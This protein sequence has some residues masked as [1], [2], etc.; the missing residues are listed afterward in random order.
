MKLET[1]QKYIDIMDSMIDS[2]YTSVRDYCEHVGINY[3]TF[4]VQMYNMRKLAGQ[5]SE[6]CQRAIDKYE[7]VKE[8]FLQGKRSGLNNH[9][10]SNRQSYKDKLIAERDRIDK[11]LKELE[12][13]ESNN[14]E[15]E[16][17]ENAEIDEDK[18]ENYMD[19]IKLLN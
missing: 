4:S 3:N 2:D 9:S 16:D 10:G 18:L 14:D 11:E 15:D 6:A 12:D 19:N 13:K 8:L 7:E 1:I 5:Y 17:E